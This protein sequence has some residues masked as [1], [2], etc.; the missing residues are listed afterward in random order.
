M[1]FH[2]VSRLS[3]SYPY[4]VY[5]YKD[6]CNCEISEVSTDFVN[7]SVVFVREKRKQNENW[8][9]NVIFR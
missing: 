2:N 9:K 3:S 1:R 5:E 8:S 4:S 6:N 7:I